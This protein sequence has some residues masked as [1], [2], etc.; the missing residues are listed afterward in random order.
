[1]KKLA[2]LLIPAVM[3]AA[4][5][6]TNERGETVPDRTSTGAI[7]GAVTGAVVGKQ[8]G[9]D[10]KGTVIGAVVGGAAGAA[11]GKKMD[12]Q[13]REYREALRQ[14]QLAKEIEVERVRND[15]L[16]LTLSSE[17]SFDVDSATIR[18]AFCSSLD[19]VANI[20]VKYPDTRIT[21][22][23]HTDSTGSESYN[24]QLSERRARSVVTYLTNKGIEGYRL[25]PM[26][27]GETEPR[28]DN[29]TAAG[30][31]ANRRVEIYVQQQ[32]S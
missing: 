22:V 23:G 16:K 8:V 6:T 27:R 31:E 18:P 11:I 15:V 32:A 21:V 30:R 13:E 1:M 2:Y 4:C 20:M 9:G 12:N 26:G 24:Q 19:K 28:A 3:S 10:T 7:I 25:T 17:V 5:T 14:E 29:R